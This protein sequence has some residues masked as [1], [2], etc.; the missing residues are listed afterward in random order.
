[1]VQYKRRIGYSLH[2]ELRPSNR[3]E[4]VVKAPEIA[5]EPIV[6]KVSWWMMI[7]N[8]ILKWIR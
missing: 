5:P 7:Y 1:M 6:V 8:Q 4:Q 3:V 2:P